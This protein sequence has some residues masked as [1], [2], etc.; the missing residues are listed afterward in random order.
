MSNLRY[1]GVVHLEPNQHTVRVLITH[2]EV[3]QKNELVLDTLF[4][5]DRVLFRVC[6]SL[7]VG[8]IKNNGLP[9]RERL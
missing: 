2:Y 5:C 8:D 7:W 9:R 3:R 4:D 6:K 1:D